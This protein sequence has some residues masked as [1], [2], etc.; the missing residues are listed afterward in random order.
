MQVPLEI[1]FHNIDPSP[2]IEAKVRRKARWLERYFGRVTSC[3]VVI[4]A[5]HRH[6]NKGNHYHVKVFMSL[7]G[8]HVVTASRDA[9]QGHAHEDLYAAVHDA[10]EAARRQLQD[11]ADKMSGKV[12]TLRGPRH[13]LP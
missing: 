13:R 3:R 9:D 2:A 12:K 10:F 5:P 7:P 4:E 8:G 6:H 1:T 11:T